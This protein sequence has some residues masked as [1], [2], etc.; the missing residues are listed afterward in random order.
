MLNIM[1]VLVLA[2]LVY[3]VISGVLLNL[4]PLI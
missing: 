1:M 2:L 4:N 3:S